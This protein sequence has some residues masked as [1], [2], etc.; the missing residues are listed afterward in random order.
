[1]SIELAKPLNEAV[2]ISLGQDEL[3]TLQTRFKLR[4]MLPNCLS[5]IHS[6]IFLQKGLTIGNFIIF[7]AMDGPDL[8][9]HDISIKPYYNR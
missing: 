2:Q 5:S 9:Y 1:M 7:L 6:S 4:K 8:E 3:E